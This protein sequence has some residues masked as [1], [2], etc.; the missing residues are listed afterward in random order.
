MLGRVGG[1]EM[2]PL[3]LCLSV[4]WRALC[5]HPYPILAPDCVFTPLSRPQ[6]DRA[7]NEERPLFEDVGGCTPEA[8]DALAALC[9]S[10]GPVLGALEGAGVEG[11]GEEGAG[12]DPTAPDDTPLAQVCAGVFVCTPC[13]LCGT[14]LSAGV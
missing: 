12:V 3:G 2:C 13:W 6:A 14:R 10:L 7:H 8:R 5:P 11:E 9:T 4:A 1:G